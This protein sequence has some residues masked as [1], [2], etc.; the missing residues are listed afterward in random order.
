LS[1]VE[2]LTVL[3]VLLYCCVLLYRCVF[4]PQN[5]KAPKSM[6]VKVG[7]VV[8]DRHVVQVQM[9]R[10][11]STLRALW[12]A[13]SINI[14][15]RTEGEPVVLDVYTMGSV[16]ISLPMLSKGQQKMF[17]EKMAA[18]PEAA[19][20]GSGATKR[21]TPEA[22]AA[23]AVKAAVAAE[24]AEQA[25]VTSENKSNNRNK[26]SMNKPA[27]EKN[28]KESSSGPLIQDVTEVDELD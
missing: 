14:T 8:D 23:A 12:S 6:W 19:S 25:T 28:I 5:I 2:V 13:P 1:I 9:V 16:F 4:F 21:V 15:N 27:V 10:T 17:E 20:N 18:M 26:D 22:L 11:T 24:Q 3:F 7:S